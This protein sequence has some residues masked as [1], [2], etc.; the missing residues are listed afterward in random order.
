MHHAPSGGSDTSTASGKL[1]RHGVA[2]SGTNITSGVT[3]AG[4]GADPS[5]VD[6]DFERLG[7]TPAS[8]SS[9]G[10]VSRGRLAKSFEILLGFL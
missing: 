9:E 5:G 7:E 8:Y 4:I 1:A 3:G 10:D 2:M 6:R